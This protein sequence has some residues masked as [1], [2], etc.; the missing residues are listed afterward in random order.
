M[1]HLSLVTPSR[2]HNQDDL[3]EAYKEY[4]PIDRFLR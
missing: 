2:H 1:P 4:G 3:G